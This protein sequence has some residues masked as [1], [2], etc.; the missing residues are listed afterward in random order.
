L[1]AWAIVT[2]LIVCSKSS[3]PFL[4]RILPIQHGLPRRSLTGLEIYE[5]IHVN[6]IRVLWLAPDALHFF[7][8]HFPSFSSAFGAAGAVPRSQNELDCGFLNSIP[9]L[10]AP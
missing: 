2:I 8:A 1:D 3:I 4:L 9:D 10:Q 7:P 6:G 5:C